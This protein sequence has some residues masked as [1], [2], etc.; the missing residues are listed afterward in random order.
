MDFDTAR[1]RAFV[2]VVERGSVAGAAEHL[3]YSGP[4][5]SQQLAK[6]ERQIGS[7]LFSRI[8]G[9]LRVSANGERLLPTARMI[10][11]LADQAA[12]VALGSGPTTVSITAFASAIQTLILPLLDTKSLRDFVITVR[13]A[14]DA[15]ALSDLRAGDT[16]I[17]VVQEYTGARP[18][19]TRGFTYTHLCADR[20]RLIGPRAMSPAVQLTDLANASW[21]VNGTGTR[22]EE[23]AERLLSDAGVTPT[24]TG[25]IADNETLLAMVAAG[26][27]TTIVPELVLTGQR[28]RLTIAPVDLGVRRNLLAVTRTGS[29]QGLA[30]LIAQLRAIGS[31][32]T[33]TAS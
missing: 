29:E 26:H 27:G 22:C 1:L 15:I 24:I 25:R 12:L 5:I 7:P 16:D 10:I 9:R 11:E 21:L 17:A 2:Q 6:L 3:G 4:G 14:D 19:R 33:S 32:L 13:D 8:G 28:R 20:L 23:V 18:S 30:P 31:Q